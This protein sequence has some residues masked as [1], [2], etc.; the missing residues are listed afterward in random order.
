MTI[1]TFAAELNIGKLTS[2]N[3][4]ANRPE[5][6]ST[7]FI[8]NKVHAAARILDF[9]IVTLDRREFRSETE[10]SLAIKLKVETEARWGFSYLT[11]VIAWQC[12]Q[13]AIAVLHCDPVEH[14]AR[15]NPDGTLN[16][17]LIGPWAHTWGA[18]NPAQF[19]RFALPVKRTGGHLPGSGVQAHSASPDY[20][21][22]GLILICHEACGR[23]VW[24]ALANGRHVIS[25]ARH[26]AVLAAA[27]G[28]LTG[29]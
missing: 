27:R 10:D 21:R 15:H 7:G 5:S 11:E 17:E 28:L 3:F 2:A 20:A 9:T 6:I 25:G 8:L 14:T 24:E 19:T 4:G 22:H 18:F 23:R 26:D 29:A 12:W 1:K 13:D 16:G